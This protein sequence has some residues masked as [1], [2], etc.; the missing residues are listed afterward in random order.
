MHLSG[1]CCLHGGTSR[2]DCSWWIFTYKSTGS[3]NPVRLFTSLHTHM[4]KNMNL[5]KP[6][7]SLEYKHSKNAEQ[8]KP[9]T[10]VIL[11][12]FGNTTCWLLTGPLASPDKCRAAGT[13]QS[14]ISN[15]SDLQLIL[16]G[17]FQGRGGKGQPQCQTPNQLARFQL[18]IVFI[19]VKSW[20]HKFR[21]TLWR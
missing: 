21:S 11:L 6:F 8:G 18:E 15:A 2:G 7:A 13:A 10:A 16:W 20:I 17:W 3:S 19:S 9:F 1:V 14:S 4:Q 12:C 5:A